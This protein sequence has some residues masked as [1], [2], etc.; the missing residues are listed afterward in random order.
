[1][2]SKKTLRSFGPL[3]SVGGFF[4]ITAYDGFEGG[5]QFKDC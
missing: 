4:T 2:E 5:A 1:M 3:R